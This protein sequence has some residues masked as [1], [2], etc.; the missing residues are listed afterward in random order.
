VS[1]K[2]TLK[3][4]LAVLVSALLFSPTAQ[5]AGDSATGW[6]YDFFGQAGN[7][8][9]VTTGCQC[10]NTPTAVTGIA[11]ATQVASADY[12]SLFLLS[13]GTV[14]GVG[15]NLDGELGNGTT[16]DSTAPVAVSGLANVVAVATGDSHSLALLSNGTVMA[17]GSNSNGQLGIG[18][19]SGPEDCSGTPCSK[20]PLVVPGISDAIAISAAGA[21]NLV[22]L[23]NGTAVT[24]GHDRFGQLGDGVGVAG[25]CE[26][27]D[28]PVP[29]AG[30]PPAMAISTGGFEASA[31]LADGTVRNWGHNAHGGLG[32]GAVT[33]ASGCECLAPVAVSGLGGVKAIA[34]GTLFGMALLADGGVRSWGYNHFGELGTG[35][36]SANSCECIA[37][38]VAVSGLSGVRAISAGVDHG[39][40]LLADGSARSWGRNGEGQ[41]GDG[42]N[43]QREAPVP[44]SGVNA[45]AVSAAN[46][47]GFALTG[48]SQALDVAIAGAGAGTVG[49]P[50]GILCPASCAGSYPQGQ[51]EILRAEPAPGSSFAGF[52]GACTGT[53]TCQ[54]RMDAN[55]SVSA[56]FGP[57]KGTV[58]TA[59]KVSSRKKK[60]EFSFSAPGAI[61]GYEC[62]LNRP[63]GR[64]PKKHKPKRGHGKGHGQAGSKAR[65]GASGHKQPKPIFASCAAPKAYKHLRPGSYTFQVRALDILGAD[66]VPASKRFKIKAPRHK[67][68]H[69]PRAT[70]AA[71]LRGTP[72]SGRPADL[73]QSGSPEKGGGPNLNHMLNGTLEV[74]GR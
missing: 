54:V 40:A 5:A 70:Q 41:L 13:D 59:A 15:R 27:V 24:W 51:V 3:A 65:K 10:L 46:Y 71:V 55:Q 56:T 29:I 45:V 9:A 18:S 8:A 47:G 16:A 7:G 21:Y 69:K 38:P 25:G 32:T 72:T 2:T 30:L 68:S 60:A 67:R 57:P 61:T 12:H 23:S 58:I 11:G 62:K 39:L 66:A 22:L 17:W 35:S 42:S 14:R 4:F 31:L 34:A 6:G 36:V 74:Q 48:P 43:S 44:V 37:S 19:S 50:K 49:G 52:S 63:K 20:A 26:C 1:A 53:G 64:K 73:L 33:P 28:H